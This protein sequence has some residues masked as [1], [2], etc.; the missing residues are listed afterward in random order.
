MLRL[1]LLSVSLLFMLLVLSLFFF[2]RKYLIELTEQANC[3]MLF[4]V[5]L[6]GNYTF[7]AACDDMCE[8][9]KYDV[10]ETGIG[11]VKI[12]SGESATNQPIIYVKKWTEYLR[13]DK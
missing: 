5:S 11:R 2:K 13:W 9:W 12:E 3:E 8:L 4:Q 6:S 7:Y 10:T 1:S